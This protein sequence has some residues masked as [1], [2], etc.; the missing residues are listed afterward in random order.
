M[1]FVYCA[2]AICYMLR[3]FRNIDETKLLNFIRRSWN[4]DGGF[5]QCPGLES[6]GGST[7]CAIASLCMLDRLPVVLASRRFEKLLQWCV[8]KQSDGFHGRPSKPDDS[9]YTFW[10]GAT[11]KLLNSTHLIDERKVVEFTLS[12]QDDVI[13]GFGKHPDVM[14]DVLHA[15]MSISGLAI[16]GRPPLRPVDPALNISQAATTHWRSLDGP[17]PPLRTEEDLLADKTA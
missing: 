12:T 10:L 14:P 7:F 15:Y 16:L 2:V 4:Y 3:D 1:R 8:W 13:G 9:C 5:A 6:H 11:L 17:Q